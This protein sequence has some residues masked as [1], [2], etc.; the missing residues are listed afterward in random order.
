MMMVVVVMMMMLMMQTYA[1]RHSN[2]KSE[3]GMLY[4]K[5]GFNV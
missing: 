4:R 5:R 2:R 3:L 1:V